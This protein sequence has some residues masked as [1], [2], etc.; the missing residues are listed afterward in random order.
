ML[1][2]TYSLLRVEV[3]S[4]KRV[5]SEVNKSPNFSHCVV[6]FMKVI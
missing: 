1:L 5:K 2:T 4:K 6:K 3:V